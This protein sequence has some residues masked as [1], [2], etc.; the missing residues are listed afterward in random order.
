MII[1]IAF[2]ESE[3]RHQKR[4]ARAASC[5]IRLAPDCM[6]GRVNQ[7]RAV[8]EHDDL[9]YAANEETS[10]RADPS[11][12]PR[13]EQRGQSK[14]HQHREQVNMSMLPHHQRIFLQIGHVIERRLGPELE[15]QPADVRV[16]KAFRYVVRIFVVIDMFMMAPMLAR[17]HQN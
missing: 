17:P 2:A 15:Q 11:V 1:V 5:R 13:A 9:G 10:E 3:Y 6:A 7:E 14:T 4:I 16:E 12:P 8:L